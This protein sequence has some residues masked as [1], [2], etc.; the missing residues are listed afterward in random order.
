MRRGESGF[1]RELG[2]FN[3]HVFEFAGIE[4]IPAIEACDEFGVL[5]A[6]YDLHT[7]V[8]TLIH[9]ASLLG[10]CDGGIEIHK[11]GAITSARKGLSEICRK[12]PVF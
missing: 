8:L 1:V 4:D 6:G 3:S 2:L 9:D 11:P 5:L 12:F 10:S 7:G